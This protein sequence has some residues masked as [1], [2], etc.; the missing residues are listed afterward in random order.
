MPVRTYAAYAS[1]QP[2]HHWRKA[3]VAGFNYFLLS[4]VSQPVAGKT[5]TWNQRNLTWALLVQGIDSVRSLVVSSFGHLIYTA[6]LA[7]ARELARSGSSLPIHSHGKGWIWKC[8]CDTL[9][10]LK[11]IQLIQ[12]TIHVKI[13]NLNWGS[14]VTV[15]SHLQ[16]GQQHRWP[17][18]PFFQFFGII[19]SSIF[20]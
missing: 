2:H 19:H 7:L 11:K 3:W 5:C 18:M 17:Y 4:A 1:V 14:A 20:I 10:A 6:T 15:Y 12:A 9:A 8:I 13:H 16:K